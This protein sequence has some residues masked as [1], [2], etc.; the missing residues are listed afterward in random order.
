MIGVRCR[1]A[2]SALLLWSKRLHAA[3]ITSID[4]NIIRSEKS[5]NSHQWIEWEACVIWKTLS[6]STSF[7]YINWG[8]TSLVWK[9]EFHNV[10]ER[11]WESLISHNKIKDLPPWFEVSSKICTALLVYWRAFNSGDGG[12]LEFSRSVV[13]WAGNTDS[14]VMRAHFV[15]S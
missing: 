14:V 10:R 2:A 11:R 3:I 4:V 6:E 5:W 13:K 8:E 12:D 9:E 1:V 15:L 7:I